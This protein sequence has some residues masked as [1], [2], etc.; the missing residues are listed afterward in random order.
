VEAALKTSE[1]IL[2]GYNNNK[3]ERANIKI[4]LEE[5]ISAL[6]QVKAD[7]SIT[8]NQARGT[9]IGK[10]SFDPTG[11]NRPGNKRQHI[12]PGTGR[13]L[14]SV[15]HDCCLTGHWK[16]DEVCPI[17]QAR[18]RKQKMKG[19]KNRSQIQKK[20]GKTEHTDSGEEENANS[21][22][23]HLVEKVFQ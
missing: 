6:S 10:R 8:P 20:K 16:G 23:D 5:A 9:M 13:K 14:N 18:Q 21:D 22:S 11:S 17:E 3:E 4:S 1:R 15:C 19:H 2:V 7:S 12:A